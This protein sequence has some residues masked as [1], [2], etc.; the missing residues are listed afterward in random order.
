[1]AKDVQDVVCS[2]GDDQSSEAGI[3]S[4]RHNPFLAA[5]WSYY[6]VDCRA[7]SMTAAASGQRTVKGPLSVVGPL[8]PAG[9]SRALAC[10]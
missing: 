8:R 6:E 4:S 2:C 7:D 5:K 3:L 1:M 9:S 10:I